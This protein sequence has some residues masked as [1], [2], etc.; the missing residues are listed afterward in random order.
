MIMKREVRGLCYF[1]LISTRDNKTIRNL[2]RVTSCSAVPTGDQVSDTGAVI[3]FPK[4]N[5]EASSHGS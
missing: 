4:G 2:G 1:L 5:K 3:S